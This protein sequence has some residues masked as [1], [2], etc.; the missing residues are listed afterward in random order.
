MTWTPI[1]PFGYSGAATTS[2]GLVSLITDVGRI[3][4]LA[5][6]PKA[7]DTIYAG[8]SQGG[9]FR[10]LDRGASWWPISDWTNSPAEEVGAVLVATDG[11]LYAGFGGNNDDRTLGYLEPG[12][13]VRRLRISTQTWE[14]LS[15]PTTTCVVQNSPPTAEQNE[16]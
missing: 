14:D 7:P 6:D 1:G 9:V 8:S 16:S 4:D 15:T 13:G 11:N 2:D 10:S 12:S 5:F 3:N